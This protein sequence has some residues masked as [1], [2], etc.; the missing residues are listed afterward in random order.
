[1]NDLLD[2]VIAR[3]GGLR[4]WNRI[5]ALE[6][7]MSITGSTWPRKGWP[8]ALKDVHVSAHA[9]IQWISYMPFTGENK[10]SR[11]TPDLTIIE[12]LDGQVLKKRRDPRSAFESH[13]A[14]TQWDD[15]HI[16]YFSG[17]AM[18]NYLTTPF[19]FAGE[20][21]AVEE[22]PPCRDA[23]EERRRLKVI[24]PR[25]IATHCREQVFYVDDNDL[26]TRMDYVADARDEDAAPFLAG[27]HM[28]DADRAGFLRLA[29]PVELDPDAAVF[30]G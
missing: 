11:C 30:V 12:T 23:G 15:L 4:R 13:T 2:R 20:G 7:D 10:R 27:P 17:Y 22:L 9:Q 29:I 26:I 21:F 24:F 6:G 3:H 28:G 25:A 16:A 19:V 8:D 1:M 18:W 5:T 14:Q